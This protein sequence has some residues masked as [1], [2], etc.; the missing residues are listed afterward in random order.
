MILVA[1]THGA[2]ICHRFSEVYL[3]LPGHWTGIADEDIKNLQKGPGGRNSV[4]G[5]M[6]DRLYDSAWIEVM[7]NA[8]YHDDSGLTFLLS[9]DSEDNL[10]LL[11]ASHDQVPS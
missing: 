5:W 6:Q 11:D 1:S 9:F 7:E 8:R 3:D 4:E 10:V 2:R